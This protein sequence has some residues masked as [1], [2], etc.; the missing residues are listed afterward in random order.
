MRGIVKLTPIIKDYPWGNDYF[1]ANLLGQEHSG[2]KAEL[3]IGAHKSGSSIMSCASGECDGNCCYGR[4][5][6]EYL[7]EHS[8]FLGDESGEFPFLLKGLA[9][10]EPLSLQ[11]HPN[12]QQAK[13]GYE[14]KNVSYQDPNP[15]AEILYAL[16]PI[17]L[18]CGFRSLEEI[19]ANFELVVPNVWK[20]FFSKV[21]SIAQFFHILYHL[22]EE[23]QLYSIK[24]LSENKKAL[25]SDQL[26]VFDIVY[27]KYK[28][29]SVFAPLF[30]NVVRLK[31]GQA[32][33]FRPCIL[34]SYVLGNG[35][36]L[37]NNSDNILR[38]GLTQKHIDVEEFESIMCTEPYFPKPMQS[39]ITQE[40]QRFSTLDG[41]A[42]TVIKETISLIETK[43]PKLFLC[44]E[45]S[46]A[47]GPDCVLEKGECCIAGNQAE[48]YK[49]DATNGS[50]FMA[51]KTF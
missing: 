19:K 27:S 34:H 43:G 3:W 38:A 35:I 7:Q 32:I 26:E 17:L 16:T 11:C 6:I 23:E 31:E 22:S 50:A 37:T 25:K 48:D 9:I 10:G 5:L 20:R 18:M 13:V 42:L 29:P 14:S 46:V 51:S 28:D 47:I 12:A 39:E 8:N 33:Y 36:E 2:P 44:T 1:I 41:F 45:G 49:V 40:G 4:P 24:Q 21:G 15:K 30:L